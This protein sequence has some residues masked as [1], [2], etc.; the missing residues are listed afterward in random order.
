MR[1][2]RFGWFL[3][4]A[5]VGLVTGFFVRP[6]EAGGL[7][8]TM[9]LTQAKIPGGLTE[10]KLLGFA[11][12]NSMKLLHE[13]K[14]DDIKKRK[15]KANLVVSFNKPVDDMEFQVLFYDI[16][17]ARRLVD[18]MSTMINKRNEKTFVQQLSMDRPMFKPNRQMELVVTVKRAEV[19]TLK[20][21]V[22]GEEIKRSGQVSF[23]DEETG[24]KKK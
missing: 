15:W 8:A 19:G 13:T 7:K 10:A 1:G 22:L 5:A 17:D 12:A 20:F 24:P 6:A 23:S 9:Y 16:Q 14:D 4:L 11:R 21:G 3:T 18:D 2:R